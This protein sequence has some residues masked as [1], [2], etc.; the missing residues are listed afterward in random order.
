MVRVLG[1]GSKSYRFESYCLP[2]YNSIFLNVS[3]VFILK[4]K[5]IFLELKTY[6]NITLFPAFLCMATLNYHQ[7]WKNP[8]NPF[9]VAMFPDSSRF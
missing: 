6:Y 5:Y 4:L 2:R 9:I 3:L 7:R 1:C 8:E